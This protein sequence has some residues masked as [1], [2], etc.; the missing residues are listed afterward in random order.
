MSIK[1]TVIGI[2]ELKDNLSSVLKDVQNNLVRVL[3]T[4]RNMVIAELCAPLLDRSER[5]TKTEASWVNEGVLSLPQRAI[6]PLPKSPVSLPDGT[7][8]ALLAKERAE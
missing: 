6:A 7:T 4:D 3:I 1:T 5:L 8:A 2:R